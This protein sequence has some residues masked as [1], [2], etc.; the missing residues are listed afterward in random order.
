MQ[1]MVISVVV[2]FRH[3]LPYRPVV[4]K[5]FC[6]VNDRDFNNYSIIGK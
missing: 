1:L 4:L 2:C 6:A 3:T 5:T